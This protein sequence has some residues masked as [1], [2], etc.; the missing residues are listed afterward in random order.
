MKLCSTLARL[1]C[2][3]FSVLTLLLAWPS[4]GGLS[5]SAPKAPATSG[6][7]S[8]QTKGAVSSGENQNADS[9]F[10]EAESLREEQ[11]AESNA[12]AI[13]KYKDAA[14]VWRAAGEF[15][16]AASAFR[17]AGEFCRL[18]GDTKGA[19]SHYKESIA[20][21]KKTKSFLEESRVLNDLGYLQFIA[22][23]T[24]EARKNCKLALQL[25]KAIGNDSVVAQ[26]ISNMGETFFAFGDLTKAV[27]HQQQALSIWRRLG[28]QRGQAQALVALGYYQSNLGDPAK[29][30]ESFAQA[31][32]LSR[33]INDLEG[34]ALALIA[35]GFLIARMGETQKALSAF[36]TARS[37]VERIGDRTSLARVLGGMG[38]LYL[39][40]G[41][42][43]K[44]LEHFLQNLKLFELG[45]EKWGIAEG[46]LELGRTYHAL[47]DNKQALEYLY[48]GLAL[49]K[50][51][52]M[53][54]LEAYTLREIGSVYSAIKDNKSA[55]RSYEQALKLT[56]KGQ[57]QRYEAYTLNYLGRVYED[58]EDYE[59]ALAQ[60]R[61]ALPLNHVSGDQ[62]GE[63]LTLYNI[64]HV[65]RNRGNLAEAQRQIEASTRLAESVRSNVASQDLRASYFATVRQTYELYVDVL[66][67]RYKANPGAGFAAKAFAVSERARARSFLESLHE[68]QTNIREGVDTALLARE[69]S[70]EETLN[71]KAER[72]MQLLASRDK[73]EADK[74]AKEIN[75]LTIEYAEVR[76]Q[77][78]ATSPRYAALTLP[79]PLTLTEV[80]QRV[81]DDDS[82]LLEY[83]LGDERSYVWAVTR[84]DVSSFELPPRAEIEA[85]ARD[86]YELLVGYQALP[87]EPLEQRRQREAKTDDLLPA[88]TALLS[89]LLLGPLIGKLERRRLVIVPDGA[90]QYI[91]FQALMVPETN[92]RDASQSSSEW[93]QS[94]LQ[95]HEIVNELSASTLGLLINES[96]AR[97]Q[98]PN[99]VAVLADPVFEVDDPRV[100]RARGEIREQSAESLEVRKALR[101]VRD[102]GIS[103]DGVQIPRL[104][105]SRG[106]AE[107]IMAS[108]PW[109]TGLKFL[110]FDASRAQVMGPELARYR[111]VHFATHGLINNEHPELSGIVLSLFDR[112]GNSQNGF[113]RLHDIYNL[114]LPADLV[115]LSACSSGLGKDVKGEGL[116]GLTR[117]FMYA[118][119]SGVVASLWKVDDDATSELM[120]NF[121]Q[122]IF[123]KGLSPS[124]ALRDAQL[125]MSRQKRW[126]AAYY[127]AGFVIQGQYNQKE[128]MGRRF[129][130]TMKQLVVLAVF[131][132]TL[133]L[134]SFFIFKSRRGQN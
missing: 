11:R 37:L 122:A 73:V 77:I 64:A 17:N 113:L 120:K 55:L 96:A 68:S 38:D 100:S 52:S 79:Q 84:K 21:S 66:M 115:V 130:L 53:P 134:V 127:W 91:P 92:L 20:L 121:Y 18:L 26:A 40:L 62:A 6:Q 39:G 56:R 85:A 132:S 5:H 43:Q 86:F 57:D 129:F 31:L 63:V 93:N 107:S 44:A 69:R 90:L 46:K 87:G 25:G 10:A 75:S 128:D 94:L 117:G 102:I 126:H 1:S 12:R 35:N 22:G 8:A 54:R 80:Q 71:A 33:G 119:A 61:R 114:H 78:R 50:T 112:Q 116:I 14:E 27:E 74:V 123:T 70:L 16:K 51:L 4:F 99:A 88:K 106:E 81:L 95:N 2:A 19:L 34:E 65:E 89:K 67:Q 49:F 58:L 60:Y 30:R 101:D 45:D 42:K 28:D 9:S 105:A 3:C 124:A 41:D 24:G 131:A 82:V 72:Q 109:G 36:G 76:D 110:D 98:A 108:A 29:A 23:N 118:G 111:I 59:R 97:K 13:E 104:F 32:S 133:L 15:E 83:A 47:G 103:P 125:A 48:E 7:S